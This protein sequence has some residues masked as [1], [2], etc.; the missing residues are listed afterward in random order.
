MSLREIFRRS[1]QQ[2]DRRGISESKESAEH[3]LACAMNLTRKELREILSTR[4]DILVAE[5]AASTFEIFCKKRLENMP[6][7]YIVG[8]WDFHDLRGL[9]MRKTVLIPR[10]ETEEL[11]DFAAEILR[12]IVQET[13]SRPVQV[14]DIG[15]GTGAIGLALLNVFPSIVC[16]ACDVSPVAVDLANENAKRF[17]FSD[18]YRCVRSDIANLTQTFPDMAGSFDAIVSNPPYIPSAD[19]SLLQT[20]VDLYE[21]HTA[22]W[23]GREGLDVIGSILSAASELTRD[24]SGAPIILEVDSG[25]PRRMDQWIEEMPFRAEIDFAEWR[26]DIF[27]SPR[28]CLFRTT[29]REKDLRRGKGPVTE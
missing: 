29:G 27:G 9:H 7:Q 16:V 17:G 12:P 14:L 15:A 21:D 3:L 4:K 25:H 6:V 5:E 18:R 2:F 19:M 24:D 11:V 20:E 10:P 1:V 23:G 28:M 8:E 13:A 26:R 22:L